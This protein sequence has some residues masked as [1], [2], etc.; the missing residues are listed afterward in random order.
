MEQLLR[1]WQYVP[2]TN[3]FEVQDICKEVAET[4]HAKKCPCCNGKILCSEE[5]LEKLGKCP[6]CC[7]NDM[8][9]EQYCDYIEDLDALEHF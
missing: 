7:L 2:L 8:L 6:D 1:I 4:A 5:V 9:Y 3:S